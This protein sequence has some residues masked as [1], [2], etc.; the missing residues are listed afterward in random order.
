MFKYMV[1]QLKE[2]ISKFVSGEEN[3]MGDV[4]EIVKTLVLIVVIGAIGVFIADKTMTAT[5]TPANTT[6]ANI[7]RNILDASSTGSSFIVILLIAFIGGI[8]ISYLAFFT[9][10]GRK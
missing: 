2:K 7:S 10:R 3:G 8:A 6:L 9:G 5:G 4:I 1:K